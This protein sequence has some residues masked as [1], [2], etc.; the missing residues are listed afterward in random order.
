M[1]QNGVKSLLNK[2]HIVM[3]LKLQ[4]VASFRHPKF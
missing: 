4:I 3:Q 1:M 2:I